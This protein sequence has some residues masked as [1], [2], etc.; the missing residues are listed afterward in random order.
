MQIKGVNANTVSVM[1]AAR[2]VREN[3]VQIRLE[4]NMFGPECKVTIS[5]EGRNLSEQQTAQEKTGVRDA[6]LDKE[7]RMLLRRL[8]EDML[9]KK[10]RQGYREELDEIEKQINVLS[11]AYGRMKENKAYSDPLM[12][13]IVEQQRL[14]QEEMQEQKD[15]QREE[16][17]RRLKAA[18]QIAAMQTSQYKEEIDENN[19]DLVTLLKTM[20]EARKA[21]D[22]RENGVSKDSGDSASGTE[23]SVGD[24]IRD[25]AAGFMESSFNREKGVE[26]L[27][28]MVKDGG[29]WFLSQADDITRNLFKKGASI[30]EAIGDKSFT[31]EQIDEMMQGYRSEVRVKGAEA[32]IFGSFGM[33]VLR[34]MQD[35]K[36]QRIADS[37]LQNMQQTKNGM[38]AAAVDAALG[39]ARQSGI[40]KASRKLADEV[41]ELIDE[42]NDIDRIPKEKEE[43]EEEPGRMQEEQLQTEV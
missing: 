10:T 18:Q 41:Q 40:D 31:N 15:F 37:P 3:G 21:E 26:E 28:N 39:A 24:A 36:I 8:D 29:R 30:K 17:Q 42:R 38:T 7:T 9:A 6:S 14:L 35:G 27:S 4:D 20:E 43:D 13:E 2:D 5:E 23:D 22:E 11:A 25:S 12:K 33:Q 1:P 16:G 19:R 32:Y 34:D